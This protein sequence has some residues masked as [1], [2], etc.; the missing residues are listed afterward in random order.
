M[1][2]GFSKNALSYLLFLRLVPVFPFF[3][4]NLV[5]AFL[6][7]PLTTYVAGT[8]IGIV[9]GTFIFASFGAGLGAALDRGK[10]V[11]YAPPIWRQVMR[12]IR[13]LPRWVMRRVEF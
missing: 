3:V 12:V 8:A 7:V 9:P 1:R 10:P 13:R 2:T 11:V 5:P 6:G 4:V